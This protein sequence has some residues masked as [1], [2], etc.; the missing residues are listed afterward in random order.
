[1]RPTKLIDP[2][3]WP[4]PVVFVVALIGVFLLSGVVVSLAI[5]L[6]GS[7]EAFAAAKQAALPW[8]FLWRWACY[9]ALILA[10]LKLWK[11]RVLARLGEDRDGGEAARDRLKRLESL[12]LVVMVGIEL[13]NVLD[14]LG[15]RS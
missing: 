1:M 12:T 11:P 10:W 15:G 6:M 5:Q 7:R 2:R 14:W 3:R 9:A 4:S 8:L 13:F